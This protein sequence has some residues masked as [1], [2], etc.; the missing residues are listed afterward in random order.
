MQC[1]ND[2]LG[3]GNNGYY[4]HLVNILKCKQIKIKTQWKQILHFRSPLLLCTFG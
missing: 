1:F 3:I 4:I 2:F